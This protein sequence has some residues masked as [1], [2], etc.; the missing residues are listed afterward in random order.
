MRSNPLLLLVGAAVL[1]APVPALSANK[2]ITGS[3]AKDGYTVIAL[4]YGGK[5]S[6]SRV[7]KGKFRVIPR[8]KVVTLHLRTASGSYVGPVVVGM[9]GKRAVLGV[10]AGAK[11]GKLVLSKGFAK[12][13][14]AIRRSLTDRGRTAVSRNGRPIGA[15]RFGLVRAPATGKAGAGQDLDLDGVANAFDIDDDGDLVLDN[16]DRRNGATPRQTQP[17][18][19]DPNAGPPPGDPN[20]GAQPPAEQGLRLFSNF[21]F[22]LDETLNANAGGVTREQIDAAMTKAD[23]FVGLV[24]FLPQGIASAELDCGGLSYCSAGGTGR[25]SEPFPAGPPFPAAFDA[26]GDGLGTITRGATGDFQLRTFAPSAA[27]G[28]GDTFIEQLPDGSQISGSLNYMFNTTPAVKSYVDGGGAGATVSY[29]AASDAP[30]T[31][32][33]PLVLQPDAAGHYTLSLTLWRPQRDAIAEAGEAPGFMDIGGLTYQLVIP[34]GPLQPVPGAGGAGGGEG[35]GTCNLDAF[36]SSD[37]NLQTTL[38]PFGRRDASLDAPADPNS[39]LTMTIDFTRCLAQA[40]QALT[41]GD[42]LGWEIQANSVVGDVAA[43]GW[44]VCV[45]KAGATDCKVSGPPGPP[46]PPTA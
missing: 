30:G 12:P 20:A 10:K 18:P 40:G 32:S 36:T 9:K 7:V 21:H 13:V 35:P 43:Q 2:P 39:T 3:L 24:F 46:V 45:P 17:P 37:P 44:Q 14:R 1:A 25:A 22:S 23:S 6:S 28:S 38:P 41:P 34:N 42:Q 27:I 33:N 11:L 19:G 31:V 16:N 5:T 15:G 29:P 4:G 26:D 8:N